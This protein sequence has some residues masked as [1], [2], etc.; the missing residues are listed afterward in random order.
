MII[1][2]VIPL[3]EYHV[4]PI[5]W[6]TKRIDLIPMIFTFFFCFY[7]T[8]LGIFVGVGISLLMFVYANM[9]LKL[10]ENREDN[11]VTIKVGAQAIYYPSAEQLISKLEKII[12][13]KKSKPDVLI[14]DLEKVEKLDS[15]SATLLQQFWLACVGQINGPKFQFT[16]ALGDTRRILLANG[17]VIDEEIQLEELKSLKKSEAPEIE[18]GDPERIYPKLDE[19]EF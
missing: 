7:E 9:K 19:H 1:A 10:T 6:R 17:V 15:T 5:L 3:F 13:N 2:A 4:V 14:L 12:G 18:N 16:N 11:I 8:E